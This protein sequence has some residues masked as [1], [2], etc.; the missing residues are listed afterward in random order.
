MQQNIKTTL[1]RLWAFVDVSDSAHQAFSAGDPHSGGGCHTPFLHSIDKEIGTKVYLT[2][3]CETKAH[4]IREKS[5][6]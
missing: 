2:R 4:E 6:L 3:T 1:G 5:G